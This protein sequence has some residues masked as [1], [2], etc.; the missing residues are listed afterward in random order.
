MSRNNVTDAE[1]AELQNRYSY[2][3]PKGDQPDRYN[4]V[5]ET[6]LALAQVIV[7][8]CPNSRERSTALTQLDM[9]MMNANAAIARNE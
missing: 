1:Y 4:R 6:C 2:H 9:V 3:S 7:E 8:N 5:R